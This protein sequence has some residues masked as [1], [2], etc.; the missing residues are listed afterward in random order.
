MS[1]CS[2][3]IITFLSSVT[4]SLL[5]HRLLIIS[6]PPDPNQSHPLHLTPLHVPHCWCQTLNESPCV[7]VCMCARACTCVFMCAKGS[8]LVA[9]TIGPPTAFCSDALSPPQTIMG[10]Q[11]K[12]PSNLS[13]APSLSLFVLLSLLISP[14][15][16]FHLSCFFL[17]WVLKYFHSASTWCLL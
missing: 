7:C 2:L 14:S 3:L 10:K 1:T 6:P 11:L 9:R 4:S 13:C 5:L 15:H 8:G 17:N 12:T 16:P